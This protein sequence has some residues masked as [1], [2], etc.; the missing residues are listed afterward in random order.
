MV[1]LKTFV[2][3]EGEVVLLKR[4]LLV[5]KLILPSDALGPDSGVPY[6]KGVVLPF[7]SQ[8]GKVRTMYWL[9]QAGLL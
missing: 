2:P 1:Y 5:I 6:T 9:F 7:P 4:E 8:Q 3:K